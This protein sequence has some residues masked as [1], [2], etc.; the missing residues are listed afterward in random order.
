LVNY[1]TIGVTTGTDLFE[2]RLTGDHL[3]ELPDCLRDLANLT[4]L[5]L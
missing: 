5:H 4:G 3:T 1:F 2:L